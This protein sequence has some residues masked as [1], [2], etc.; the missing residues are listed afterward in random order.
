MSHTPCVCVC[1]RLTQSCTLNIQAV[2]STLYCL[3]GLGLLFVRA[4]AHLV[5]MPVE[6]RFLKRHKTILCI[7][8]TEKPANKM[9]RQ[10]KQREEEEKI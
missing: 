2:D 8:S 3:H 9:K 6:K 1:M 10:Q 5:T 7:E 4:R